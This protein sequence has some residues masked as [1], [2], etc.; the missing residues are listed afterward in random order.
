MPFFWFS[1]V[2]AVLALEQQN[3]CKGH[4]PR[5]WA[6][7]VSNFAVEQKNGVIKGFADYFSNSLHGLEENAQ[8]VFPLQEK[9]KVEMLLWYVRLEGSAKEIVKKKHI[10]KVRRRL[11]SIFIRTFKLKVEYFDGYANRR[12]YGGY[13]S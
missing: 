10:E 2:I 11:K 6:H 9:L 8:R 5:R 1:I 12:D 13:H 4:F 7:G 3:Q